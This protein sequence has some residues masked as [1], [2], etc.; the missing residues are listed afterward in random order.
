MFQIK[1]N[2]VYFFMY[3]FSFLDGT[4][5]Y[6]IKKISLLKT[7]TTLCPLPFIPSNFKVKIMHGWKP[8]SIARFGGL[9]F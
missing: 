3:L 7:I 4:F 1:N 6:R 5:H 8:F 9:V 2:T